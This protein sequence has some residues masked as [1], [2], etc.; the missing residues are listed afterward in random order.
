MKPRDTL[1]YRQLC[2]HANQSEILHVHSQQHVRL[3]IIDAN[4]VRRR[5]GEAPD[6]SRGTHAMAIYHKD[7]LIDCNLAGDD[8]SDQTSNSV[9]FLMSLC[10]RILVRTLL[11]RYVTKGLE[12]TEETNFQHQLLDL[13]KAL[14]PKCSVVDTNMPSGIHWFNQFVILID[15]AV[16]PIQAISYHLP[17]QNGSAY[18]SRA[19]TIHN[20]R[21]EVQMVT[22]ITLVSNVVPNTK[23]HTLRSQK[24]ETAIRNVQPL[25]EIVQDDAL[26]YWCQNMVNCMSGKQFGMVMDSYDRQQ[27]RKHG[28]K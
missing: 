9:Q 7:T 16:G 10:A 26:T 17:V 25:A 3:E 8:L 5:F 18:V 12:P 15:R 14:L 27:T 4:A 1:G 24:I 23:E 28:K 2:L 19:L 21:R 11:H 6:E 20:P 22:K 13:I